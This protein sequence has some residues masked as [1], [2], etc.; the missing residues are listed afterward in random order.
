[1]AAA[2]GYLTF[3]DELNSSPD[4]QDFHGR[5]ALLVRG[6]IDYAAFGTFLGVDVTANQQLL[7]QDPGAWQ[8]GIWFWM[9]RQTPADA[10]A[11]A[12]TC[13]AAIAQGNFGQTVR[14]VAR[15][16]MSAK[17]VTARYLENCML[18]GVDPGNTTCP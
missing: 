9:L 13:H 2:T 6:R 14:L 17:E 11:S 10:G 1:V 5:G 15:D 7:S 4:E 18:L 16:C 12:P 8:S 3:T